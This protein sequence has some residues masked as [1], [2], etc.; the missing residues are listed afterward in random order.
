MLRP[1]YLDFDDAKCNKMMKKLGGSRVAGQ[2]TGIVL[3][4][5]GVGMVIFIADATTAIPEEKFTDQDAVLMTISGIFGVGVFI[6]GV[7]MTVASELLAAILMSI[8]YTAKQG[9]A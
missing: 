5:L 8:R 9:D 6:C 7:I 1:N 3:G 2:V 4:L